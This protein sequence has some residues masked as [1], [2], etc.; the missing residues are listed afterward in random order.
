MMKQIMAAL[1]FSFAQAACAID[2]GGLAEEVD[3]MVE[4]LFAQAVMSS[5]QRGEVEQARDQFRWLAERGNP[6][7]QYGLGTIY[8]EGQGVL[9]DYEQ[10]L[11]WYGRAARQG[12]APAQVRLARM[13]YLGKGVPR[14]DELAYVWS[15]LAALAGDETGRS[16]RDRLALQMD[17]ASLAA[18]RTTARE[19]A[20]RYRLR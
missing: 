1:C 6:T 2:L 3:R 16:A 8:E 18:A 17:P 11:Q 14:S 13:Y 9:P 12:H 7:A 15:Y 4:E 5:L 20:L 10:A 19:W